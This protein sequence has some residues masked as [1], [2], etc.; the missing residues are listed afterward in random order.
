MAG[1]PAGGAFAGL[2]AA[3]IVG[4]YDWRLSLV[5]IILPSC[6]CIVLLKFFA[7]KIS[8]PGAKGRFLLH[9]FST[10]DCF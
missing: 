4:Q 6:I 7:G 10:L 3:F 8:T 2:M 1:V 9:Q 5:A